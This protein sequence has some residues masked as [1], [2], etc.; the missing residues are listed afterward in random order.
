M[1]SKLVES[2]EQIIYMGLRVVLGVNVKVT[3]LVPESIKMSLS[4]LGLVVDEVLAA[5][6]VIVD[7]EFGLG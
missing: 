4:V 6:R 2:A 3:D 7:G 5:T 1:H